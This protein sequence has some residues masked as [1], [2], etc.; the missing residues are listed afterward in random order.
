MD[1]RARVAGA[2]LFC[3]ADRPERFGKAVAAADL[4]ILDLEDGVAAQNRARAREALVRAAP[5]LDPDRTVV[6]VNP[7][8][9]ADFAADLAALDR[10]GLRLV[11]LAK[12]E[13]A[14]QPA[15]LGPARDVIALCETPAGV[16]AAPAIAAAANV[17]ALMWGAE[18]LLAAIG[19][20]SSRHPDGRYRDV[21]RHAASSVLLAAA[22]RGR[23]A[24]DAVYLDIPDLDGLAAE[25]RDAAAT[26]YAA[27]ACIHPSQVA[28]VREAF[29]P[30]ET[31]LAWADR[32]LR[33]AEQAG[34]GVFA[35]EGQM[36]DAP[37]LRHAE[38]LLRAAGLDPESD[39]GR[40]P[41]L[42]QAARPR[43]G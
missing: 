19:G 23:A 11:M 12:T 15:R 21:A 34:G 41:P 18:D 22:A 1:G 5:D 26:G 27:K 20:R 4:V 9:S 29:R 36:V 30:G 32:V 3:P 16:L 6:R 35:F 17:V 24:I 8:T 33:A 37:V 38:H 2:L 39:L 42:K 7:A 25:A 31:E 40:L 10:T 28:V 13:S 14:D 43:E